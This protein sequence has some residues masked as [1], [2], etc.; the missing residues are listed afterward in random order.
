MNKVLVSILVLV[1]GAVSASAA[2]TSCGPGY[3][4]AARANIDGIK[5]AEC[6]KLWCR[7]LETGKYMGNGA[8][9]AA[10]YKDTSYTTELCDADRNCVECFGERVWCKGEVAGDWNPEYGAYT[11]G[12]DSTTHQSYQ[13]GSCFAWRLE[14]HDCAPGQTAV[15]SGNEWICTTVGSAGGAVGAV[16]KSSSVRRTSSSRRVLR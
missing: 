1:M 15:L 11:R 12:G 4:L 16:T 7:D 3:V 14:K 10:G 13:K 6:Q 9:P 2:V 8:K 5:A